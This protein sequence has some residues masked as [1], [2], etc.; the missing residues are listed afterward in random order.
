MISFLSSFVVKVLLLCMS[1]FILS[2][3]CSFER[4]LKAE[5]NALHASFSRCI[6]FSCKAILKR[7]ISEYAIYKLFQGEFAKLPDIMIVEINL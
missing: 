4:I 2:D 5:L 7:S 6:N 3:A 1:I